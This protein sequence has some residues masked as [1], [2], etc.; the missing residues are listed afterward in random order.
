MATMILTAFHRNVFVQITLEPDPT[1]H[2]H[3][4]AMTTFVILVILGLDS[5]IQ[6]CIVIT[7]CGMVRDVDLQAAVVN[8]T[9]LHGF[10]RVCHKS[11]LIKSSRRYV[12]QVMRKF[13]SI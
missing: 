6:P 2:L 13:T 3:L 1:G 8:L 4:L 12:V 10:T 7:Q 9:T 5:P 11:P